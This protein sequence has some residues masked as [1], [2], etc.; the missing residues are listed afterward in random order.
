M[1]EIIINY[2]NKA[3]LVRLATALGY[4][5]PVGKA[6]TTQGAIATGGSYFFNN[7]GQV[8]A[9]PAVYDSSTFPPTI[10]TPA[11]MAPGLWGRLRV[12]G[13]TSS[14]PQIIAACRALGVVIYERG[15]DGAWIDAPDFV[16]RVGVVA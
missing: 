15:E 3:A 4:Y 6:I 5:D 1:T 10:V 13:D 2:P 16:D 11:V 9:T 12:N 8:V 7:V 14:L